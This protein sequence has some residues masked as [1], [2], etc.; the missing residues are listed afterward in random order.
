V[1]Q[2]VVALLAGGLGAPIPEELAL[3]GA[4]YWIWHGSDATT[5]AVAGL[6]AVLAGD[7]TLYAFGRG[8][9]QLALVRRIVGPE[10]RQRLERAF[11]RHGAKLVLAGRFVPGL[12]AAMLVAAGASRMPLGRMALWDGA[13]A[14]AAVTLW[15][16]VG[17]RL[18]PQIARAR[19]IVE[20]GRAVALAAAVVFAVVLVVRRWALGA[21]RGPTEQLADREV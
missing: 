14:C 19:A 12:R 18:G 5:L 11:T 10:R 7:L 8:G 3:V 20:G 21:R 16:S 15:I 6:C 2:L 4:G 13:G 1:L 9:A 17:V